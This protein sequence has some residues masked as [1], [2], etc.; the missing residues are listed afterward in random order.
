MRQADKKKGLTKN[1]PNKRS[2]TR[3]NKNTTAQKSPILTRED[4]TNHELAEH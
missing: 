2:T 3:A 4:P 1:A